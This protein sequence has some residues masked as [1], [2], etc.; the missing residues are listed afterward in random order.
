MVRWSS[1]DPDRNAARLEE[2]LDE[3]ALCRGVLLKW[4]ERVE[5]G[6]TPAS[7]GECL[8]D[9]M[10]VAYGAAPA[11]LAPATLQGVERHL[12]HCARCVEMFCSTP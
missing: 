4:S 6:T 11:N 12:R 2:H 1:S 8:D 9:E 5:G 3:C 10:L 7:S